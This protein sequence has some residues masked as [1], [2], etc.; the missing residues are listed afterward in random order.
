MDLPDRN[1][2][3]RKLIAPARHSVQRSGQRCP[4][5]NILTVFTGLL[6]AVALGGLADWV[7]AR[8]GMRRGLALAIV[9]VG[10]LGVM[11]GGAWAIGATAAEQR[12]SARM[13]W[14]A[15]SSSGFPTP[16]PAPM[17]RPSGRPGGR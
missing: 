11:V 16:A 9:I 13:R 5:G 4:G 12:P 2:H 10:L 7:T 3:R 15:S 8:T 14:A 6:L 1:A 17:R